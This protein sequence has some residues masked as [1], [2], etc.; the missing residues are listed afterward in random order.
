MEDELRK[1]DRDFITNYLLSSDKLEKISILVVAYVS[2]N[3]TTG[4]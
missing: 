2:P 3:Q 1:V 4:S